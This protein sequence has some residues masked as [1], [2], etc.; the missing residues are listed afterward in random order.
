MKPNSY[1]SSNLD[2][3]NSKN[4]IQRNP[5]QKLLVARFINKINNLITEINPKTLLDIGCGEGIV[6]SKLL[7]QHKKLK[8]TGIDL[9]KKTVQQAKNKNPNAKFQTMDATK[10]KLKNNS[11]D[12]TLNLEILEHLDNPG[13]AIKEA[14]RV[15]KKYCTVSMVFKGYFFR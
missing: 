12:L 9:N 2:K 7:N 1:R 14:K 4:F 11:F 13:K 3:Y 10:L 15:S 8:I 6:I 5:L